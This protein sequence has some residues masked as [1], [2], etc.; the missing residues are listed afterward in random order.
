MLVYAYAFNTQKA[1]AT[2]T[3][4]EDAVW[5]DRAVDARV[6]TSFRCAVADGATETSYSRLWAHQLVNA[7]SNRALD[8]E[9]L[10]ELPRLQAKWQGSV[11]K[12]VARANNWWTGQKAA[13][14]AFAAFVGVEFS[15]GTAPDRG[16]WR[17]TALGDCCLFHVRAD[18]LVRSFPIER[19]DA[20]ND[21]P[22]LLPSIPAQN[23][24]MLDRLMHA[25]DVWQANDSFYL[26][27]D[28]IAH[29]FLTQSEAGER[30]W[31]QLRDLG[32]DSTTFVSWIE[33]LR[34]AGSLKNDDVT[35]LRV[36]LFPGEVL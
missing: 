10:A 17:A 9:T 34:A 32:T 2:W 7:Y 4:Y 22:L 3:E 18:Q 15:N 1:G 14:G 6:C 23:A 27:S 26:L 25:S 21:R 13:S 12:R 16:E 31:A 5:P 8:G 20:F 35:V 11:S 30:P 36:D 24:E 28:A 19:A 33:Q 29:W